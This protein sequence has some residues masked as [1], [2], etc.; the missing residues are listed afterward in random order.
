MGFFDDVLGPDPLHPA[1]KSI[2]GAESAGNPQAV[3]PNSTAA[4]LG[5]FIDDTWAQFIQEKHPEKLA[6]GQDIYSLKTDP[7]LSVEATDWYAKKNEAHLAEKGLP[8]DP[9]SIYLAHFAGPAGAEALL[10]SS[11]E[12]SAADILGPAA[13]KAN[14]F[15]ANM[16]VADVQ[17]WARRKVGGPGETKVAQGF[18]DDVLGPEQAAP[19]ATGGFFDDV[20][21][22]ENA[23]PGLPSPEQPELP[24]GDATNGDA[25]AGEG[26][27]QPSPVVPPPAAAPEVKDPNQPG[28]FDWF[29]R[30]KYQYDTRN[31]M[32]QTLNGKKDI[33]TAAAEFKELVKAQAAIPER[34]E[35]VEGAKAMARYEAGKAP[36]YEGVRGWLKFFYDHP[37]YSL[38]T[39]GE[40]GFSMAESTAVGALGAVAGAPLGPIGMA[41]GMATGVGASSGLTEGISKFTEALQDEGIDITSEES[42]Q[43]AF[44]NTELLARAREKAILKGAAV[45]VIDG[46]T[47][48]LGA[49][50]V[51]KPIAE[52]IGKVI[53]KEAVRKG[54]TRKAIEESAAEL[55]FLEAPGG[56]AGEALGE[57]AS[58]GEIANPISV[59]MEG[60][61]EI[62]LGGPQVAIQTA[63]AKEGRETAVADVGRIKEVVTAI[64][65]IPSYEEAALEG[66]NWFGFVE[67]GYDTDAPGGGN[68]SAANTRVYQS[69]SYAEEL[70]GDYDPR[71]GKL[72]AVGDNDITATSAD[73]SQQT[74]STKNPPKP[75]FI[76][77]E[78]EA[79][80]QELWT[81]FVNEGGAK[82]Y[83]EAV[84]LGLRLAPQADH[85]EFVGDI[86]SSEILPKSELVARNDTLNVFVADPGSTTGTTQSYSFKAPVNLVSLLQDARFAVTP[87]KSGLLRLARHGRKAQFAPSVFEVLDPGMEADIQANGWGAFVDKLAALPAEDSKELFRKGQIK[88]RPSLAWN[89]RT[90]NPSSG[91]AALE[92]VSSLPEKETNAALNTHAAT[93]PKSG[94]PVQEVEQTPWIS[95]LQYPA[96]PISAQPI[97]N[98]AG[99]KVSYVYGTTADK[100]YKTIIEGWGEIAQR[101]M[102]N[103]KIKERLIVVAVDKND[104]DS[105]QNQFTWGPNDWA[106]FRGWTQDPDAAAF[107]SSTASG[108]AI[109]FLPPMSH[110]RQVGVW[111]HEFGHAIAYWSLAH[112]D[113]KHQAQIYAAYRRY[114]LMYRTATKSRALDHYVR[115]GLS[116]T[117]HSSDNYFKTFEEWF[118][119]QVGRWGQT[120]AKPL[121]KVAKFFRHVAKEI[122]YALKTFRQTYGDAMMAEPVIQ[123]WLDAVYMD[124]PWSV[125]IRETLVEKTR[126]ANMKHG[127]NVPLQAES[128]KASSVLEAMLSP[129]P[130]ANSGTPGNHTLGAIKAQL[131]KFNWLM[132]WGYSYLQVAQENRHIPEVNLYA[133]GMQM[134]RL[135]VNNIMAEAE[136]ILKQ[137]IRPLHSQ[138]TAGKSQVERLAD[139]LFDM[140]EM[141]YRNSS[142]VIKGIRR[143]PTAQEFQLFV[144]KHKLSNEAVTA[145][146]Q[147]RGFFVKT[148]LRGEE[149]AIAEARAVFAN[150]PIQLQLAIAN[151]Q[152]LTRRLLAAPYFPMTRFG[153]WAVTVRNATGGVERFETFESKK[154]Q[155]QA[156]AEAKRQYPETA[157]WSVRAS[158]LPDDVKGF[159]G[160]P[161][162]FLDRLQSMPGMTPQQQEWMKLLRYQV[163][164][165][166]S[167]RKHLLPRKRTAGYSRDLERVFA[168]YAFQHARNYGRIKYQRFLEQQIKGLRGMVFQPGHGDV[169]S[170]SRIANFLQDHFN[171]VMNPSADWHMLRSATSVWYLGMVPSSAALNMTQSIIMTTPFLGTKFGDARAMK[172]MT[173][174]NAQLSTFYKRGS[175]EGQTEAHMR[176]LDFLIKR[177]DITESMA[178]E[179]AGLAAGNSLDSYFGFGEKLQRGWLAFA[180]KAML[181]FKLVEQWNR[182]VTARATFDLA[183]ADPNNEYV[184]S[185]KNRYYLQYQQMLNSGFGTETE[186]LATLT[187]GDSILSTHYDYSKEARPRFMRG[188]AG[189]LFAFYMFTQNTVF[190]LTSRENK[191]LFIRYALIMTLMSG[192]MGMLPEEGE[193]ILNFVGKKFF[194][195]D[196][197]LDLEARR[198]LNN[199]MSPEY[200]DLIL[201]GTGRY[202]FGIPH[203]MDALGGP[204]MP[205]V[206]FSRLVELR[207]IAPLPITKGLLL[208]SGKDVEKKISDWVQDMAGA[209]FGLPFNWAMALF[210]GELDW[211]DPKR[212]E[213]AVPRAMGKVMQA[214][215]RYNEEGHRVGRSNTVLEYDTSDPQD[216]AEIIAIGLGFTTRR[217]ALNWDVA[218]AKQEVSMFWKSKRQA[219][220]ARAYEAKLGKWKNDEMWGEVLQT[221]KEFNKEAPDPTLRITMDTVKKS[222]KARQRTEHD[223]LEGEGPN[224]PPVLGK[225]IRSQFPD[226]QRVG[227][228]KVKLGFP[229]VP[230]GQ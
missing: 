205:E 195:K 151:A 95:S 211:S 89:S 32:I 224:I 79:K 134:S 143:N 76:I 39:L 156:F 166:R 216:V 70:M 182:R 81:T 176:M 94:M 9:G 24:L 178:A 46:F 139:F 30:S 126:A 159:A 119:E 99:G 107:M 158:V 215:R 74:M 61:G 170:R 227:E 109:L 226:T 181:M 82:N 62:A 189:L 131:D 96:R 64:T 3:N 217:E 127:V 4:G 72:V 8:T 111:A 69:Y 199:L 67:Q 55:F 200:S 130:P 84:K 112:L 11:P 13:T 187:A 78:S 136:T 118:A 87:T 92:I 172:A 58:E 192:T 154:E 146:E 214:W 91:L 185:M 213:R 31:V 42:L 100:N 16:R 190:Q 209:G 169:N 85:A 208:D 160:M 135:D 108:D 132:K 167:F 20:L 106:S 6:A 113:P 124:R 77:P 21:G 80:A 204:P 137:F 49:R 50:G 197:N 86:T 41:A 102:N 122:I 202:G 206:D 105:I 186:I 56:M 22:P 173:K 93:L 114:V 196:F 25:P 193:D 171:E 129:T 104:I 60:A 63:I 88:L 149:V 54:A 28:L 165:A 90:F 148:V 53:G 210:D 66:R 184:Q 83:R 36:E 7:N 115:R 145:Y 203:L 15:L 212:W 17:E 177:G 164:P 222:F 101:L 191:G 35:Y 51:G 1:V 121:G 23:A 140:T 201:H 174:A 47:S 48:L 152:L 141:N 155:Q 138:R 180:D 175:Y 183:M 40:S 168:R 219:I 163:A 116:L 147:L 10:R 198:L 144:Q 228:Q 150:D 2:I 98:F 207:N 57:L 43:G 27:G 44:A 12:A 29:W 34:K 97:Q 157:G 218:A 161:P 179:L 223:F 37:T 142:E 125:G 18:F 220:L 194:G 52:S 103:L 33:P 230:S 123:D 128:V 71:K 73:A 110:R 59:M 225:E 65:D 26:A 153:E 120:S 133:E 162:W 221:I 75:R 117:G 45:G 68:A 188:R 5:Q 19:S 229:S 38:E 14:P